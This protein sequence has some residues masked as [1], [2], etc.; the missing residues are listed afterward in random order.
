MKKIKKTYKKVK[1]FF[2]HLN[3]SINYMHDLSGIPRFI[4]FFDIVWCRIRY[5][6]SHNEYR[7][8][9]FYNIDGNKRKTY[10]NIRRHKRMEKYLLDEKIINVINDKDLFLKRFDE[11]VKRD[12]ID[13]DDLSFKEYENYCLKNKKILCRSNK[14]SFLKTYKIY[15]V[16]DFRSPAYMIEKIKKDKLVLIEKCY[17]Q[18]KKLKEINEELVLIN[19]TSIYNEGKCNIISS[20]IKFKDGNEIISGSIDTKNGVLVGHL[21]DSDGK[22]YSNKYAGYEIPKYEEIIK[23]VKKLS[24]EMEEIKEIEWTF[25]INSRGTIY[26]MDANIY[27][28]FVFAQTPEFLKNKIG[29]YPQYKKVRKSIIGF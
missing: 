12:V 9:E 15:D 28:D 14:S 2:K 11:Y 5:G 4:L 20:S 13:V 25:S 24:K 29:F 18:Y 7:I 17:S 10:L 26:L 21:K 19:V 16:K 27:E 22:N 8:Y 1:N 23:R 3:K 6:L